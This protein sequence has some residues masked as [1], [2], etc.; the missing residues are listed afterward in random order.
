VWSD[1]PNDVQMRWLDEDGHVTTVRHPS[2]NSNGNTFDYQGPSAVVRARRPPRM[3]RSWPRIRT[4]GWGARA[5]LS[6]WML[7]GA[8]RAW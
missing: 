5:A 2:G 4:A 6:L 7:A 3:H 8:P 1:I